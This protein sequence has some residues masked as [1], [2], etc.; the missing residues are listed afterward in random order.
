MTGPHPGS[1]PHRRCAACR[2]RRPKGELLRFVRTPGG[3]PPGGGGV[4]VEVDGPQRAPGRGAYTCLDETCVERGLQRGGLARTLRVPIGQDEA[5]A[6]RASAV[7]YLR[8]RTIQ[9]A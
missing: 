6:L 8:E 5:Q 3:G 4:H 7:E 9:G 2:Q 1:V